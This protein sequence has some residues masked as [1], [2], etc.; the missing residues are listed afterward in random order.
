M[1]ESPIILNINEEDIELDA[2]VTSAIEDHDDEIQ[3]A[4]GREGIHDER[5]VISAFSSAFIHTERFKDIFKQVASIA[6]S[7]AKN[8]GFNDG[9]KRTAV[10]QINTLLVSLLLV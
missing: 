3:K 8:H 5:M 7:L 4:G 10:R 6:T 9:N 1:C 2:F